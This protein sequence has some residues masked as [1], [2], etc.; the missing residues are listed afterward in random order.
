MA[1]QKRG[2]KARRVKLVVR[3]IPPHVTPAQL[4]EALQKAQVPSFTLLRFVAPQAWHD[5]STYLSK[6]SVA[7]VVV[8][9]EDEAAAFANIVSRTVAFPKHLPKTDSDEKNEDELEVTEETEEPELQ[10]LQ[11]TMAMNQLLPEMPKQDS[12]QGTCAKDEDFLLEQAKYTAFCEGRTL[13]PEEEEKIAPRLSKSLAKQRALEQKRE[14]QAKLAKEKAIKTT[15]LQGAVTEETPAIVNF[16][17]RA[18]D[19]KSGKSKQKSSSKSDKKQQQQQKQQQQKQQKQQTTK[20]KADTSDTKKSKAPLR[21]TSKQKKALEPKIEAEV[22]KRL[23]ELDIADDVERRKQREKLLQRTRT[24][25]YKHEAKLLEVQALAKATPSAAA[26]ADSDSK[27]KQRKQR[28][29]E[30]KQ[31]QQQQQQQLQP[32]GV[33]K[34]KQKN[35]KDKKDRKNKKNKRDKNKE[36]AAPSADAPA[37]VP[38]FS[39]AAPSFTPGFSANMPAFNP[40]SQ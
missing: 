21:L 25:F 4:Q 1:S 33:K 5:T 30:K 2:R 35:K 17:V 9:S 22:A 24:R 7:Y 8:N 10:Q 15:K 13:T 12:R 18:H 14:T 36:Q 37:F 38:S 19:S 31:Q 40:N 3:S 34:A 39:A 29:K 6:S 27:K 20:T 23:A 16:L 32:Q 11:V 26:T 28:Q